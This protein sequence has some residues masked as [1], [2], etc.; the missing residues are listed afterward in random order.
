MEKESLDGSSALSILRV[1]EASKTWTCNSKE[2]LKY[3]D[4]LSLIVVLLI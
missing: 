3:R 4:V 1:L 2:L